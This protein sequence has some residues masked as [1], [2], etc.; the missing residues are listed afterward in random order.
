V[1]KEHGIGNA[2]VLTG[3]DLQVLGTRFGRPWVVGVK[4]P[5]GE[6]ILYNFPASPGE[7]IST[8]GD[9]ERQQMIG[10]KRYHHIFDPRTGYPTDT[11]ASVTVISSVPEYATGSP[12][13]SMVVG[14]MVSEAPGSLSRSA[15]YPDDADL[16]VI[17]SRE[18]ETRLR[19]KPGAPAIEWR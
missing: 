1:L 18:L 15:D 12:L 14:R 6:S 19:A 4:N 5:R 16:K 10:G 9:Y 3:G 8:S 13:P 17:A 11:F 7:T 2:L